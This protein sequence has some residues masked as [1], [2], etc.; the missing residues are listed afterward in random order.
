M[1]TLTVLRYAQQ[2]KEKQFGI[3]VQKSFGESGVKSVSRWTVASTAALES[4]ALLSCG[5]IQL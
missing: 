1:E 4:L 2:A 3:R 5:V